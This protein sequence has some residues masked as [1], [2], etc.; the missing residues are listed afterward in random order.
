MSNILR[1][2]LRSAASCLLAILVFELLT[3]PVFPAEKG[4][5]APLAELLQIGAADNV[6]VDGILDEPFWG[7]T[8]PIGD[9]TMVEP[10]EGAP[11]SERTEVRVSASVSALYIGIMCY[12]SSPDRIVSYT[13]QRDAELRSEDH[14][15]L[16]F[17]TFLNG[18][19][20][21]IFA[22]NP[23]G[24]RYDALIEKE[25]E[26]ENREWDG[27]WEAAV[28]RSPEGWSAEIYLPVKTLRFARGLD[29][30]GFNVERRIERRLETDR[31]A[32]PLLNYKV[33]HVS[34][35]GILEPVPEF[36]QGWGLTVR[37]Y[38]RGDRTK[39]EYGAP[40]VNDATAGLDIKKN[41]GGNVSGLLSL[42]TDFAE[43]E[44]DTRR[45]NLTRF[46]LLYPE[47]R[48]IF[49]EGSDVFDFG[50][51]MGFH[52]RFDLIPFYSRRIGLIEGQVVPLDLS[53]KA[54]GGVSRFNFGVLDVMTR[55]VDELAPRT[56]LFA[57]RGYQGL[58]KESR[59]GFLATAGDPLGR[60]GSYQVGAD[61]IYKTTQFQGDKNLLLGVWGLV[62]GREDLGKDNTAFGFAVDLPND[63]WDVSVSAKRIGA[64]FDPSMGYVPWR[65]VYKARFDL[66]YKP[67]PSLSWLRQIWYEL[68]TSIVTD[69][70]G[71]VQQWGIFTAPVNWHLESGDRIEFNIYPQWERIPERFEITDEVYI[72]PGTYQWWRYRLELQTAGK[73]RVG[74]K[75]SWWFGGYYDGHLNQIQLTATWRP[76]HHVNVALEGETNFVRVSSGDADILL[77]RAR[78]DIFITSNFQLL[79]YVQY[80]NLSDSLGVNCR[81]RY[82]YRSLLDIFL[83]FNHNWLEI[84]NIFRTDLNQFLLKVQYSWRR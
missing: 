28:H 80:D 44:V 52:H 55:P 71:Q 3:G 54:T 59:V 83:V 78:A 30:W 72:D 56:N 60:P 21:Y 50:L 37:P 41:F 15:K 11:P 2:A 14:I 68:F 23:N 20:G 70:N 17:D 49:L 82:T 5:A 45:I 58:W 35:A 67:R 29:R 8:R 51:G 1:V 53:V 40:H 34:R 46:P 36:E 73:R 32:S 84:D 27:I 75:V 18:R 16:V 61:F 47:K 64:D 39:E 63:L 76:S 79:N 12:D 81:L 57:A 66:A 22:V 33:T 31:W 38:I 65:G 10:D 43:T 6:R 24:A 4:G 7:K 25:G 13:M 62:T 9:L 48:T 26:R 69:V 74:A 77:A 42:N 19:T